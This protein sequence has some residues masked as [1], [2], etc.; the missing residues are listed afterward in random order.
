MTKKEIQETI[1]RNLSE[2]NILN[3]EKV[4]EACLSL[5]KMSNLEKKSFYKYIKIN[6]IHKL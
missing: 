1:T 3:Y 2:A 4:S 5:L 6:C